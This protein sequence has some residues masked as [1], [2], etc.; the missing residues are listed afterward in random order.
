MKKF[1]IV[2]FLFTETVQCQVN[3]SFTDGDFTQNPNWSG[4]DYQFEVNSSSQLHLISEKPD[5]SYLSTPNIKIDDTEWNFWVKLSFNT[6]SNNLARVYLV[7]DSPNLEKALNGYFVQIGGSDDSIRV[8][9][10]SGHLT[11]VIYCFRMYK[12]SH[13]TN[14]LRFKIL[15]E[16][17]GLWEAW[18]DTTGKAN[19]NKDGVFLESSYNQ[20]S[21]MGVFCKYT[22]SNATKFYFDD[23]LVE[24]IQHDSLPP[25]ILSCISTDSVSLRVKFNENVDKQSA[26]NSHH[27]YLKLSGQ[28]PLMVNQEKDLP[29][30]YLLIFERPLP[31]GTYD[32]IWISGVND[33]AGNSMKDTIVSFNY[34]LP[35]AYDVLIHEI[36][37]DP[38]PQVDLPPEEYVEL[39]NRTPFSIN[40]EKWTFH[41]GNSKKVFPPL[42]IDPYGYLLLVKDSSKFYLYGNC[43]PLFTSTISLSNEGS[44]LAIKNEKGMVIHAVAYENSWYASSYK[45]EG[46]WS[47]EMI[48]PMNPCGCQENWIASTD[49]SGGTPGRAN[50]VYAPQPDL[51]IPHLVRAFFKDST[52]I[53]LLFSESMDSIGLSTRESYILNPSGIIPDYVKPKEPMFNSVVLKFCSTFQKGIIYQIFSSGIMRDCAGN[54]MD[55]SRHLEIALPDEITDRDIII[56]EILFNPYPH[57]NRFIELFNRSGKVLDLKTL[58]IKKDDSIEGTMN[59]GYPVVQD[60]YLMFPFDYVAISSDPDEV[61][62]RYPGPPNRKTIKPEKFPTLSENSGMLVIARQDD[63]TIIDKISYSSEMQYPL[64]NSKEGVSLERIHPDRP[65][66]DQSNWHSASETVGFASPAYQNSQ[67][68]PDENLSSSILVFP[69]IF[70]PDNDGKDDC[71]HLVLEPDYAGF[72]ADVIIFDSKGSIVKRLARNVLLAAENVFSWDGITEK[73]TKAPLGFYFFFVEMLHPEGTIKRYKKVFVLGGHV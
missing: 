8:F 59:A 35:R 17:H 29:C 1:L 51:S 11:E 65:S 4:D 40:L 33:I 43:I 27:Y 37:A 60:S 52:S 47:L 67:Y 58:M 39:Y 22:S 42:S 44:M 38:I 63:G 69:L 34:Y 70:S 61:L 24:N 3:D 66:T 54:M 36:M 20:T 62:K 57:G 15:R 23:F 13:S 73:N 50:A 41:F 48:D 46:G 45:S 49:P 30:C 32:S 68:Y 56:N 31:S 72:Q 71:I 25:G 26:E 6:S 19:F 9:K 53:Q 12:A 21:W 18:L 10:Q 28:Y 2:L 64:L 5:T 55:T 7:S 16:E 14:I